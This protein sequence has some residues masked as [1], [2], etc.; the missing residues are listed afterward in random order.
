MGS[1]SLYDSKRGDREL[2]AWETDMIM[3]NRVFQTQAREYL[4]VH[5]RKQTGAC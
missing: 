3:T 4:L 2:L 1:S 5:G